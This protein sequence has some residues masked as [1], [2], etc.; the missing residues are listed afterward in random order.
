ML[1]NRKRI[2]ALA[3]WTVERRARG[4]YMRRT[5]Y[6]EPWLG[7]YSSEASV[8]LMIARRLRKELLFRDQ[9]LAQ[10]SQ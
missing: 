5:S 8:S 7:P 2:Y 9:R 6:D 1:D 3:G 4:W 10:R